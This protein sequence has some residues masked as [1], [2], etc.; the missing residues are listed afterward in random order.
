VANYQADSQ[1]RNRKR[2]KEEKPKK[3]FQKKMKLKIAYKTG[4]SMLFLKRLYEV[5]EATKISHKNYIPFPD[6]FEK[7]CRNFS[8]NKSA[9][10]EML[11]L[12]QEIGAIRIIPYH[13]I[14]LNFSVVNNEIVLYG[15]N[16]NKRE[17]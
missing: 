3:G 7:I 13:G 8:I 1:R 4:P 14:S 9:C 12:F 6:L 5:Q 15:T 2:E 16:K 11:F 10:W 17:K